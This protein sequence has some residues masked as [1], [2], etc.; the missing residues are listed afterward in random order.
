MRC[1]EDWT[2]V[3]AR[4]ADIHGRHPDIDD[5]LRRAAREAGLKRR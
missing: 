3:V 2:I 4:K 5:M 1:A